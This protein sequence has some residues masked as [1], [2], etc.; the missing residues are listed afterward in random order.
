M[1]QLIKDAI[2]NSTPR[3]KL[4]VILSILMIIFWS[5]KALTYESPEA[6]QNRIMK[7]TRIKEYDLFRLKTN[8]WATVEIK[9][10]Q[11]CIKT[12]ESN[13]WKDI[14][15]VDCFAPSDIWSTKWLDTSKFVPLKPEELFYTTKLSDKCYVSQ[16]EKEHFKSNWRLATDVACWFKVILFAPDYNNQIVEYKV[17]HYIFKDT[18]NTIVL[19]FIN[20]WTKYFWLLWH[21][22]SSD[23]LFSYDYMNWFKLKTWDVIWEMDMSWISSG[24]HSHIELWQWNN[25]ETAVKVSYSSSTKKLINARLN[26]SNIDIGW[27]YITK[28]Y[29]AVK[30]WEAFYMTSYNLWDKTQNDSAPYNWASGKD[31]R[32]V[33]NPIAITKDIREMY[34]I[35]FWDKV[36]LIWWPCPWIYQVEDDM[37]CRFRGKY[38]YKSDWKWWAIWP[39]YLTD[40]KTIANWNVKDWNGSGYYI[41]WDIA[42]PLWAK[43]QCSGVY[44]IVAPWMQY[45]WLTNK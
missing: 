35:K 4:V 39:C 32:Y 24:Y 18:W 33:K 2:T 20:D 1:N 12:N 9:R 19:E 8:S 44:K 17:K 41:K 5:Y 27:W 31:L 7:E 14:R 3:Y 38:A 23:R 42:I 40:K 30:Y 6:K 11:D 29:N 43:A 15:W 37:N 34:W 36:E 13:K 21:I 45:D 16:N 26:K 22:K 10:L 28:P 25:I